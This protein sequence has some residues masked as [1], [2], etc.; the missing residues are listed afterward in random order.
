VQHFTPKAISPG[1]I[2]EIQRF[3]GP[4]GASLGRTVEPPGIS[5]MRILWRRALA[6]QRPVGDGFDGGRIP[7]TRSARFLLRRC[8]SSQMKQAVRTARS[9]VSRRP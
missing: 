6:L 3:S 2:I 4:I 1:W 5:P 9:P 8:T 7:Y